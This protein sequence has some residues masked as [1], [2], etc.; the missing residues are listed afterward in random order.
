M[1]RKGNSTKP[2]ELAGLIGAIEH[3][4]VHQVDPPVDF[5]VDVDVEFDLQL[6]ESALQEDLPRAESARP[7]SPAG[8]P[9]R[10]KS[11]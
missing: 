1:R 4:V 5:D 10:I 3:E 6:D 2:K 11:Q 8:P 7:S 9:A